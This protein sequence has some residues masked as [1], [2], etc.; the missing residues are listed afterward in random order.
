MLLRW[1]GCTGS[2]PPRFTAYAHSNG[3]CCARRYASGD[4]NCQRHAVDHYEHDYQ[5]AHSYIYVNI[6][7][8]SDLY[9]YDN[10]YVHAVPATDKYI[11]LDTVT[12]GYTFKYQYADFYFHAIIYSWTN[13]YPNSIYYAISNEII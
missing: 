11:Y 3:H 9:R 13:K 7:T 6:Y 1:L 5:Y 4:A 2:G 8:H 10:A 12:H